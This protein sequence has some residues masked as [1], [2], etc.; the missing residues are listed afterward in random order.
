MR[1]QRSRN[2]LFC[3]TVAEA[4]C[5]CPARPVT[6][7]AI[8]KAV[9][10]LKIQG[11]W[12]SCSFSGCMNKIVFCFCYF[13]F[14]ALNKYFNLLDQGFP[15]LSTPRP[16]KNRISF[17]PSILLANQQTVLQKK[18]KKL[19]KTHTSTMFFLTFICFQ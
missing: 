7:P 1:S 14:S 2:Q 17:W 6:H 5:A 11:K 15:N 13:L 19:N 8:N 3:W 10:E 9:C 12:H 18:T 16:P 4:G